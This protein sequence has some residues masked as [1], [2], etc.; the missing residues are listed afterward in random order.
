MWIDARIIAQLK[1]AL[2]ATCCAS[3][4]RSFRVTEVLDYRPDQGTGFV[5]LAPAA[6]LNY[7]DVAVDAADP[8]R[9]PRRPTPRCS[10]A[11]RRRSRI[12]ATILIAAKAPGERLRDVE[13]SSRQL[14]SAIDRASRFLESREPRLGAARGGGG[15]H[16]RAALRGAAHRCRGLDEVHGRLAGL[17]AGDIHHRIDAAGVVRGGHRTRCSATSRSRD[18]CGCCRDLIRNELPA[19]SLAPLPIALVT[20]L[21]MLIGFAL[22]PLLQ[23]KNT[24]PARVLRKTVSAPP[25]RYGVSYLLALAALFAILWSHG[26]RHRAGVLRARR[27]ARR[28]AWC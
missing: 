21:A 13:E 2:G 24:P 17:R 11:P 25:L 26:A 20:V 18:W 12:F 23:L 10:R 7:D 22:P 28:R 15:G 1:L 9:Q 6:L 5:N 27:R 3:A 19:A 16:G 14:N 8:A 4:R